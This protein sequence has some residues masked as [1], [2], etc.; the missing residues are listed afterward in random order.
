[1]LAVRWLFPNANYDLVV[2]AAG[3]A[4]H[5]Y[6]VYYGFKGGRGMS[7]LF[8]GLILIDWLAIPVTTL[9]G[10]VIGLVVLRDIFISY[11]AGPLLLF[12]WFWWRGGDWR[13]L[14]Y[15]A[16]VNV[17]FWS[18]T[19]PEVREYYALKRAG[20]FDKGTL[21]EGLEHGHTGSLI[22]FLRKRGWIKEAPR[23]V[24]EEPIPDTD[25]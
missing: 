9:A 1:M 10:M 15:A 24:D 8:G 23:Q 18:A 5:N 25:E 14:L 7:P 19:W 4:G 11:L 21:L 6:P 2:A 17:L 20:E 13:H 3:V 22:R 16:V 12:P